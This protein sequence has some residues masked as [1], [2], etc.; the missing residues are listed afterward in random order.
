VGPLA[1]PG[2]DTTLP[3]RCPP[4]GI[5]SVRRRDP[6]SAAVLDSWL[7]RL[8]EDHR[9]RILP[10]DRAIAEEWGRMSVE[11]TGAGTLDLFARR[12]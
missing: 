1:R 2:A 10:I 4:R 6:D 9:N 3:T 12:G 11:G 7:A 8:I 5:E